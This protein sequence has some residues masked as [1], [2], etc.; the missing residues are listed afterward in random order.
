MMDAQWMKTMMMGRGAAAA[1][2]VAALVS[3][4]CATTASPATSPEQAPEW[5][6]PTQTAY[7]GWCYAVSA[8]DWS[9]TLVDR[10]PELEGFSMP[11][12]VYL[13]LEQEHG[14]MAAGIN[15]GNEELAWEDAREAR[16]IG[17]EPFDNEPWAFDHAHWWQMDDGSYRIG[18]GG[19]YLFWVGF[20]A[21]RTDDGLEGV[22]R[23]WG[24]E[25]DGEASEPEV[26]VGASLELID[27]K[28]TPF[29]VMD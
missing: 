4:G 26:M 5:R 15:T 6:P 19:S 17:E 9:P 28:G 10:F 12:V 23:Y 27:C 11:T 1:M 20:E 2:M 22:L 13:G 21:R 18:F 16:W 25:T 8:D 3:T 7:A 24:Q 14:A 29:V